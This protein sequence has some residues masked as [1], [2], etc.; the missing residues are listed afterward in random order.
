MA[1]DTTPF[2][3]KM[4]QCVISICFINLARVQA[5]YFSRKMLR[6]LKAFIMTILVSALRAIAIPSS[7]EM[8]A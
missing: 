4:E 5:E 7:F 3:S 2:T 8:I 1:N 6:D